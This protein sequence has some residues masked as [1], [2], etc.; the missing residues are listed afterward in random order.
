MKT[1]KFFSLILALATLLCAVIIPANAAETETDE[2]IEIIIE[3]ENISEETRE[4]I[5]AFYS[6]G[7]EEK[8]GIATYGLTC[9]LFGHKIESTT[10][11]TVTHKV[12]STAPRCLKK[13]YDY[14]ACTRCDY[15]ESTLKSQQY[16]ACC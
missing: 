1:K 2:H 4:K 13:V 11:S 10:I 3:N 12:R 5:I 14:E 8:E 9:T 7:G 15:E 16:I 6:D